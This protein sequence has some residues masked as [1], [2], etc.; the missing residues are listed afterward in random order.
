MASFWSLRSCWAW[1]PASPA[2]W[3][4]WPVKA[5][6]TSS[7]VAPRT[8]N[9]STAT[10]R[11]SSASSSC[12]TCAA[13]PS[14]PTLISR[15]P[16]SASRTPTQAAAR[17]TSSNADLLLEL[18]RGALRHDP[19]CVDDDDL[20]REPVGFLQVLRGEHGRHA[21]SAELG[22]DL[23]QRQPAGQIEAGRRLVEED[24]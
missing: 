21:G 12:R 6:N 15:R 4:R 3:G 22:D 7:R 10:W 1:G 16:G 9:L 17:A 18:G 5:R 24:H 11:G 23:P 2:C 20:V 13:L 19:A 8:S 14:V